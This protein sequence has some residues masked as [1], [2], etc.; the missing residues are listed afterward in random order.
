MKAHLRLFATYRDQAGRDRFELA[1][2]DGDT[3]ARA[4]ELLLDEA[5][6]L[7]RDFTPHL[8]AVNEE[9]A[10]LAY[11]LQDGDEVALY[12]P[13]SGGVDARVVSERIDVGSVTDAVRQPGNGA[14]V[15]FEGTTRDST[16]GR[17]VLRLEYEAHVSMAEKVLGQVLQE[18]AV[19]FGIDDIAARHRIGRLNIGDV[20]LAV[21]AAA[22]HRPEAFLATQ[23]AVDRIKHVVPVWKRESFE[24]GEVWVGVA[25][26]PVTH[27]QHQAEAPYAAFLAEREAR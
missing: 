25:C 24:D 16:G 6:S 9:F 5:P 19:R 1:L 17:R 15:T 12:P 2:E 8:I 20:S 7:P 11:P 21:A 22:P 4:V 13:V 14:I 23:Y 3:V 18:T 10:N 26:D 27:A